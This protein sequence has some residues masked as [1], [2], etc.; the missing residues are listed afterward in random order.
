AVDDKSQVYWS[1]LLQDIPEQKFTL[2]KGISGKADQNSFVSQGILIDAAA[3]YDLTTQIGTEINFQAGI[4]QLV[5]NSVVNMSGTA[6]GM[7]VEK[8]VNQSLPLT[9]QQVSFSL[10]K[11]TDIATIVPL[12]Q[13]DN[14][15]P[16]NKTFT[17]IIRSNLLQFSVTI[18]FGALLFLVIIL[19]YQP[20]SNT[21]IEQRRFREWITEGSVEVDNRLNINILTLEGL[22]DLAID[23][24]KR[25]IHDRGKGKYYV[26]S[27]DIAY[28]CDSKSD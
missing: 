13:M 12:T 6:N 27:E 17:D 15:K 24:D 5:V 21:A 7:P 11:S 25:V 23:L 14:S 9:L 22:V 16:S 2:T 28:I 8:S 10:P 20:K 1:Y 19:T 4:L 26:F 18:W 3:V